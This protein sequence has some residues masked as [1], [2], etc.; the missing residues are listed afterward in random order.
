VAGS[1]ATVLNYLKRKPDFVVGRKM[2]TKPHA[3][4]L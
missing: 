4:E 1:C 3:K 2:T